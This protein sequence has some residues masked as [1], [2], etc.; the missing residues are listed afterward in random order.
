MLWGIDP[1]SSWSP[2]K[3]REKKNEGKVSVGVGIRP[4]VSKLKNINQNFKMRLT[5]AQGIQNW[6]PFPNSVLIRKSYVNIY[7]MNA[8]HRNRTQ[9]LGI[10][11]R[12]ISLVS[13]NFG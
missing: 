11:T 7:L 8:A 2:L 5:V 13:H 4:E 1:T 3:R 12:C 9:D 10:H 6:V